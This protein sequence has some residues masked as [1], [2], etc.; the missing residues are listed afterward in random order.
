MSDRPPIRNAPGPGASGE[1][2]EPA[3]KETRRSLSWVREVLTRSIGLQQRR[4]QLHVVLIEPRRGVGVVPPS[5]LLLQQRAE[6]GAR[7]LVHDPATQTVRH[8][9]LVHDALGDRGWPAVDAL[10]RPVLGR[11]LAEAEMIASQEASP[12]MTGII[13]TLAELVAA[14]DKQAERDVQLQVQ[15]DML[16]KD[17]EKPAVPEVS[18][19]S[20]EEYELMERSWI[21]TVPS[22]LDLR[23]P[24][25]PNPG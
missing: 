6:L 15:R 13:A 1:A 16:R 21:G 10:P 18:E 11:A 14:A 3:A 24:R 9:F 12:L 7:L 17:W 4:N 25:L 2:R 19:A 23:E 22:G 5:D 20:H 8:L